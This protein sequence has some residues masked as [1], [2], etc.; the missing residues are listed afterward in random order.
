M[1]SIGHF[2][3]TQATRL[4]GTRSLGRLA[5]TST[6]LGAAAGT[7]AAAAAAAAAARLQQRA[8]PAALAATRPLLRQPP[9]F[10]MAGL[11]IG[12]GLTDPAA[13][14]CR[15]CWVR[16]CAGGLVAGRRLFS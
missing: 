4:N 1:P 9:L 16:A 6:G 2:I 3:L 15:S 11:A 13:Q 8:V 10:E 5:G 7:A 14:V 12:N